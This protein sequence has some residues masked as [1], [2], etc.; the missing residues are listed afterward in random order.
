MSF[1]RSIQVAALFAAIGAGCA[2]PFPAPNLVDRPRVI[3]LT[4]SPIAAM[5]GQQLTARATFGGA[6]SV[7]VRRWR[8]CVPA[9]ID[10]FPEQ[11][12]ADGEG[13]VAYTQE[14]GEALQWAIP[15]DQNQLAMLL[16]AAFV[17][18]N[19]NIPNITTAL[20]QLRANGADLFVYV[21]AV[22]DT[23]VVVRG[24]KRALFVLNA[25]RYTPLST[26]AFT[27]A[28]TRFQAAGDE[29]VPDGASSPVPIA[30]G[31]T[32]RVAIEAPATT[33]SSPIDAAHFA[34]GG[35]F[36]ERF[37]VAGIT[38]WV[39]PTTSGASTKHWVVVQRNVPR[40]S[41]AGVADVRVCS[42]SAVTR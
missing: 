2:A 20:N 9:R 12:C 4:T 41:G 15:T 26:F 6:Q 10:P 5:A 25:L 13:A 17:D 7:T 8:V 39:A 18:A 11:R 28:G 38:D 1:V 16:L 33:I 42:F 30:P 37:E 35:D 40:A 31:A 34:D 22:S 21:E 32:S 23:G 3:A 29:C 14:G 24:I 36:P 27:F 19:G